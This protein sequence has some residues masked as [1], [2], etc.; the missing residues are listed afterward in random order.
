MLHFRSCAR[1]SRHCTSHNAACRAASPRAPRAAA[2]AVFSA[3]VSTG[4]DEAPFPA[5]SAASSR[6]MT[7]RIVN[8]ADMIH[9]E[10]NLKWRNNLKKK[11]TERKEKSF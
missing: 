9:E 8:A 1:E 2:F 11:N 5:R 6:A 3:R 4:T 10:Q 7:W